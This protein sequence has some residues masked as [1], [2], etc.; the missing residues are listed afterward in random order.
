MEATDLCHQE[1]WTEVTP[2]D[3]WVSGCGL[4]DAAR[5]GLT[6]SLPFRMTNLQTN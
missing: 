5:T 2:E 6:V 3:S 1:D 4:R